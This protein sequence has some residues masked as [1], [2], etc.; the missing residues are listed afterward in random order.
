MVMP[1]NNYHILRMQSA[2]KT[3]EDASFQVRAENRKRIYP[4]ILAHPLGGGLGSTGVWGMRFSPWHQLAQFAPDSGYLR[5]MVELGTIGML[6]YAIVLARFFFLG[7]KS[8]QSKNEEIKALA[9]ALFSALSSLLLIE[10]AQDINGKVP[11]NVFFW[12]LTAVMIKLNYLPISEDSNL[13]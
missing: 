2:F 1:T 5:V 13:N 10:W 11:F 6:I 9:M 8:S 7:F 3:K 12:I 4:F